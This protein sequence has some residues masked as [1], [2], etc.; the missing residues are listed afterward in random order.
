MAN[1]LGIYLLK[2]DTRGRIFVNGPMRRYF[3]LA[4]GEDSGAYAYVGLPNDPSDKALF[5]LNESVADDIASRT[6]EEDISDFNVIPKEISKNPFK[7]IQDKFR[8]SEIK[9][10]RIQ[11]KKYELKRLGLPENDNRVIIQGAGIRFI[12][13]PVSEFKKRYPAEYERF[14]LDE[15]DDD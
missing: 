12:V 3:E 5:L 2:M 8:P 13:W 11:F 15:D 10:N 1:A 7:D 14:E 4:K 9:S 6:K